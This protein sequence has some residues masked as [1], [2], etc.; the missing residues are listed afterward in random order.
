MD[1]LSIKPEKRKG[2]LGLKLVK[3]L[4][5]GELFLYPFLNNL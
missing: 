2:I 3:L 4:S 5:K 1:K